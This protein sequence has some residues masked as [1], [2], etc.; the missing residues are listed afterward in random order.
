ALLH[1]PG[2][3]RVNVPRRGCQVDGATAP[4]RTGAAT[5]DLRGACFGGCASKRPT[6][7]CVI[8]AP[9]SRQASMRLLPVAARATHRSAGDCSARK[10]IVT[11]A[12]DGHRAP[13]ASGHRQS[14]QDRA[15]TRAKAKAAPA[16]REDHT[17]DS[18]EPRWV[19]AALTASKCGRWRVL[20]E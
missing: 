13:I 8:K 9:V 12:R 14:H 10:P 2:G 5:A 1:R 3:P 20:S 19:L 4:A 6:G 11:G 7:R 15:Y 17:R 16:D 18:P